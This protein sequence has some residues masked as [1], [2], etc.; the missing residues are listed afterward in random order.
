MKK[1]QIISFCGI[2]GSGKSEQVKSTCDFLTG[3]GYSVII[4]KMAYSPLEHYNKSKLV[5][6][7]LQLVSGE[8]IVRHFMLQR[9]TSGNCDFV[10]NDRD[11]LC[12]LAYAMA[13][14]VKNIS[15]IKKILNLISDPD[16]IF[17][18]DVKI[19]EALQR[20]DYR[21]SLRG[22]TPGAHE[23][24]DTL[25]IVKQCY[26]LLI[27]SYNNVEIIDSNKSKTEIRK[28]IESILI[29]RYNI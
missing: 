11:V 16:L 5:D 24:E 14:E 21:C 9:L 2:D 15:T 18:F 22:V 17:Y 10:L 3:I 26:E 1:A 7:L 6:L 19:E 13:Y 8:E 4:S 23:T 29:R 27:N 12:Y 28:Q 20:I 25:A